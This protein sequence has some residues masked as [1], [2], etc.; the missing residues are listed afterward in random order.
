MG[1]GLRALERPEIT[2]KQD[3]LLAKLIGIL[4]KFSQFLRQTLRNDFIPGLRRVNNAY[5]INQVHFHGY[6]LANVLLVLIAKI[7]VRFTEIFYF[8][9][10]NTCLSITPKQDYLKRACLIS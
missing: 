3:C 10:E 7:I 9:H 1:N 4:L 2:Q 5:H 6:F 8:F